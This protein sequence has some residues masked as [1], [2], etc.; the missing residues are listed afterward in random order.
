MEMCGEPWIP[1]EPMLPLE[2]LGKVAQ[3][4]IMWLLSHGNR[5]ETCPLSNTDYNPGNISLNTS[6]VVFDQKLIYAQWV[7]NVNSVFPLSP[8]PKRLNKLYFASWKNL[9]KFLILN[10][11]KR[12]GSEN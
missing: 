9:L 10:A 11:L 8:S 12:P 6:K 2:P 7:D 1:R 5:R 4:K 3:T